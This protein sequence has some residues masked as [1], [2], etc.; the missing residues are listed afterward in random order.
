MA[1]KYFGWIGSGG[2]DGVVLIKDY[3]EAYILTSEHKEFHRNDEYLK[4]AWDPGSEFDEI[5]K[6]EADKIIAKL[7]G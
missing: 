2:Y 4:A 1:E 5:T 7:K 3:S 6:E